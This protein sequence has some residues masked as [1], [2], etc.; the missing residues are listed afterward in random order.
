MARKKPTPAAALH[1]RASAS[2]EAGV[3]LDRLLGALPEQ[4]ELAPL[5]HALLRTSVPD[6]ARA[7]AHSSAYATV[8][9]RVITADALRAAA[10]DARNAAHARADALYDAVTEVLEFAAHNDDVAAALRL[11]AIGESAEAEENYRTAC[12]YYEVAG[13]FSETLADRRVRVLALRRL[14]R[15]RAALGDVDL[16]ISVFRASLEQAVAAEDIEAQVYVQL[17]LGNI[18]GFQGRWQEGSQYYEAA[19]ALCGD[20]FPRLRGQIAIN[21]AVMHRERGDLEAASAQQ[22]AASALWSEMAPA[23]HSVWYNSR[24]LLAVAR[25]ETDAA[26]T[27]FRQALETAGSDFDRAMVLD[28]LAEL[29][30]QQGNLADAEAYARAAEELALSAASPRA[31]AEIYTRLGKIFRLRSDLNG[32]TFFEKALEICR[33]RRYPLTEA[34]A[35]LEYGIFRRTLG[36]TE[37]AR[38]YIERARQLCADI[39]AAQL[40]RVASEQFAQL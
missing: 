21:L 7:W 12:A 28:N 33:G 29:F 2:A 18:M 23:D 10:A 38:S 27:I 11:I 4:H 19:R 40:E 35:Y 37:E 8:D 36:D 17:G 14:A 31:L 34:N 39:G 20:Q 6:A 30:I 15:A 16:A 26:E 22:A 32:V 9:K 25:G 1:S 13:R 3:T 5:R 24:G